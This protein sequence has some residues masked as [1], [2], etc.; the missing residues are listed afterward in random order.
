MIRMS[1]NRYLYY[2]DIMSPEDM[3]VELMGWLKE[4]YEST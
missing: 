3:D 4:S 1:A 2:M